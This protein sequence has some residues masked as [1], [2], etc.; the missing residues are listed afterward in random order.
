MALSYHLSTCRDRFTVSWCLAGGGLVYLMPRLLVE[1]RHFDTEAEGRF[2]YGQTSLYFSS[3]R[4]SLLVAR[5]FVGVLW[6]NGV[7]TVPER[8]HNP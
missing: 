4:E 2:D 8:T 3:H 7:S 5:V 6:A 1:C